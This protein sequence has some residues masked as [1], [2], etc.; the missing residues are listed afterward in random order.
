MVHIRFEGRSFSLSERQLGVTVGM[1]DMGIKRR[2][3]RHLDVGTDRLSPYIVDR[4]PT[5]NLIVR[6]VAIYG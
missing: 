2:V 1:H 4:S 3:A 6:P 5:G